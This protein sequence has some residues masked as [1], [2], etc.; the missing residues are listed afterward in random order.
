MEELS[1]NE[2]SVTDSEVW[3][4]DPIFICRALVMFLGLKDSLLEFFMKFGK[5]SDE[6]MSSGRGQFVFQMDSDGRIITLVSKEW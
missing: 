6:F 3:R 1:F 4:R 2:N 5:I